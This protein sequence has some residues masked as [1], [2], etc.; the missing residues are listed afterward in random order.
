MWSLSVLSFFLVFDLVRFW[1]WL[2]LFFFF[3]LPPPSFGVLDSIFFPSRLSPLFPIAG[4]WGRWFGSHRPVVA[5]DVIRL[6]TASVFS[7]WMF[8]STP[9]E[10]DPRPV[11]WEELGGEEWFAREGWGWVP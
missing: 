3:I 11:N 2:W 8:F 10:P 1:L 4:L 5:F 6:F 7:G 9:I